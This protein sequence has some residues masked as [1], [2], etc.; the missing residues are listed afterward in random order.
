MPQMI[1]STVRTTR[2]V[3]EEAKKARVDGEAIRFWGE[4]SGG[5]WSS[6][7][8]PLWRVYAATFAASEATE[9]LSKSV[10]RD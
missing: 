2:S 5:W 8:Y 3:V 4:K 9:R 1:F 6:E 7:S 10:K